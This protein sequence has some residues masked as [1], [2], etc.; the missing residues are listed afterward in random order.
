VELNAVQ[1]F[2]FL[3][4]EWLFEE[5]LEILSNDAKIFSKL[6]LVLKATPRH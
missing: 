3:F 5:R 1:L 4:A 6:A 2:R